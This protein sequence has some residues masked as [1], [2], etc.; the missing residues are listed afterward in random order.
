MQHIFKAL[1]SLNHA[2]IA[3]KFFSYLIMQHKFLEKN[4]ALILGVEQK[5]NET[6]LMKKLLRGVQVGLLI[7]S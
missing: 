3:L 2:K 1:Q 7:L 4:E 6:T 5:T